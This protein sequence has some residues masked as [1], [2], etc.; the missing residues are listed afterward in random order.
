MLAEARAEADA[1]IGAGRGPGG[2]GHRQHDLASRHRRPACLAAQGS[3]PPP[4]LRHRVQCRTASAPAPAARSRV[5]ISAGWCAKRSRQGCSSRVAATP[6]RRASP[7][8]RPSSASCAAFFEERAAAEV[9]RLQD[10]ESLQIDGALAAE[11]ATLALVEALEK[12]GP[13]GAGHVAPVFV[14]PRHRIADARSIGTSHIRV[15]LRS[16]SGGRIQG[17]RVSF[18]RDAA[19]RFPVQEPGPDAPCRRFAF[20]Q[21][22]ERQPH[23][24]VAR[25]RRGPGESFQPSTVCRRT[26]SS[27]CAFVAS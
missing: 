12:A 26:S 18:G 13:F 6:W 10:E 2:A 19:W 27:I 14:L 17:D 7:S 21:L 11:G 15:E 9:F 1:E 8:R 24:A 23:G 4:G 5:S 20:G 16:E 22:L 25:H 3:R